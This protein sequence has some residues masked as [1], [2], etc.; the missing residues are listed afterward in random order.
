MDADVD[1]EQPEAQVESGFRRFA[2]KHG[3]KPLGTRSG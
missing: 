2:Q 1:A 3:V